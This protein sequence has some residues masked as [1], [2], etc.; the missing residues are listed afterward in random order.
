MKKFSVTNQRK[1]WWSLSSILIV[2]GIISMIISST[3]PA[4]QFPLR[5]G[6]DFTGGSKLQYA[7]DCKVANNCKPIDIVA[8]REIVASQGIKDAVIQVVGEDST[9]LSIATKYLETDEIEKLE[10]VLGQKI[11]A[12]DKE[13]RNA[14]RVGS[15]LGQELFKNGLIAIVLSF[16]LILLYLTFRFKFDYAF[17]AFAALFHDV[18]ITT[19]V[20]SVLGLVGGVEIDSLF[21]VALLTII[22][23]SVN[24]TVVIYDR[25]REVISIN[26]DQDIDTIVDDSINQTMSRSINTT[27]TVL[28]T[29]FSIYLFGGDSLKN[30]ALCLIIGFTAGAYSSIFIASTLFGWWRKGHPPVTPSPAVVTSE[31]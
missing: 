18:L 23:F 22:G 26:P 8:V 7:L 6:L 27:L 14:F 4:I 10:A 5:R 13:K 1:W 25:I 17:F 24:D 9:G 12:L 19:G 2:I 20:F 15:T 30:F 31:S 28:L 16:G 21:V 29:L 11:G 3:N